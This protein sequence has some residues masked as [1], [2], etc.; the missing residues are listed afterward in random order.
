MDYSLSPE[1]HELREM[2]RRL[3]KEKIKPHAAEID[4]KA[5]FPWFVKELFAK[6]GLFSVVV[7]AEYGGLDGSLLTQCIVM[8]EVAKVCASS[9]MVLGNQSLGSSPIALHGN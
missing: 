3:M 4:E 5:E 9:S 1:Q 2:V 7:P 6:Q 8:E